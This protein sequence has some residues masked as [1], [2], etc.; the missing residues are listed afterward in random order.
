VART[1]GAAQRVVVCVS[2]AQ[3]MRTER[4]ERSSLGGGCG[5]ACARGTRRARSH[6]PPQGQGDAE[7]CADPRAGPRW[8]R[9]VVSRP[10][11]QSVRTLWRGVVRSDTGR[12]RAETGVQRQEQ[13]LRRPEGAGAQEARAAACWR[14]WHAAGGDAHSRPVPAVAPGTQGGAA[15][16]R[17]RRG[18]RGTRAERRP[19]HEPP[20]TA[21]PPPHLRQ[22]HPLPCRWTSRSC[23]RLCRPKSIF[24]CRRY[25]VVAAMIPVLDSKLRSAMLRAVAGRLVHSS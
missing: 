14:G 17:R 25:H 18:A 16:G 19:P 9:S 10:G 20:A 5:C 15:A 2:P 24:F 21:Q 4:R 6:E 8:V 1:C 11:A 12:G 13:S 23:S 22:R 3:A 7:R